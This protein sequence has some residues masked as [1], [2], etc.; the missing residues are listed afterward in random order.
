MEK[1]SV[2]RLTYVGIYV[3]FLLLFFTNLNAQSLSRQVIG[4]A[5]GTIDYNSAKISWTVGESI[6]GMSTATNHSVS[7]NAGFQQP[8]LSIL[9]Q[10]KESV[11]SLSI[12]P[13]PTP[14]LLNIVLLDPSQEDLQVSLT[15]SAGQA[16]VANLLLNPWKNEIDLTRF[17]AGIYFLKV[18]G[19]KNESEVFK[20]IKT[21]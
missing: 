14:D 18:S 17:P 13:N 5:G 12:S 1:R 7:V 8:E 15:N 9:P 16:L 19:Q 3:C 20:I 21:K 4:V 6:V 10:A 2:R 11:F